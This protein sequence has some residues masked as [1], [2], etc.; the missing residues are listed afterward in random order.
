M[1]YVY[2]K[3]TKAFKIISLLSGL[4]A[5]LLLV[6]SLCGIFWGQTYA[7]ETGNYASQGIGQDVVDLI[8]VVP[9]LVVST[10]LVNKKTK[11]SLFIWLGTMFYILYS[12]IIYSFAMHYN[13]LFLLYTALFGLSFYSL[14]YAFV[15]LDYN[16]VEKLFVQKKLHSFYYSFMLF[17]AGMFYLLWFKDIIP[18]IMNN[19]IPQSIIDA[20]IMTNAVYVLDLGIFLPGLIISAFLLK[21]NKPF[22]YL[23]FPAMLTFIVLMAFAIGGMMVSMYLKKETSD[24]SVGVV[25]FILSLV[26]GVILW[27]FIKNIDTTVTQ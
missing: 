5:L 17:V 3:S 14:I 26:S 24:F 22:G 27:R 12:Y 19:T 4:T 6:V 21:N 15:S 13:A 1:V 25:M 23:I 8:L 18:T 11:F 7:R 10:I 20:G 9:V 16:Q 2:L